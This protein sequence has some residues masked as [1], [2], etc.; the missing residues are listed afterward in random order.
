MVT[1]P[2]TNV[3]MEMLEKSSDALEESTEM[4]HRQM[5][6][7]AMGKYPKGLLAHSA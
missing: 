7:M 1:L 5:A 2:H 4:R 6:G 3:Y